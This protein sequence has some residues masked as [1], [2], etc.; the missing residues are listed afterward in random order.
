MTKD[1]EKC[2]RQREGER[3]WGECI[4]LLK[5]VIKIQFQSKD[6]TFHWS[7][8]AAFDNCAVHVF[9][10]MRTS[11]RF[12]Y[13]F[14][15]AR[16][17]SLVGWLEQ[18]QTDRHVLLLIRRHCLGH[19]SAGNGLGSKRVCCESYSKIITVLRHAANLSLSLAPRALRLLPLSSIWPTPALRTGVVAETP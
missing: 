10:V 9:I 17:S 7:T 2:D 5:R 6:S 8:P 19:M 12:I 13:I 3:V 11:Y 4:F 16:I 15:W 18:S 1:K 14:Y